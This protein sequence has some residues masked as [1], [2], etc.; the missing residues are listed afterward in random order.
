MHLDVV[1]RIKRFLALDRAAIA[2]SVVMRPTRVAA[3]EE[4]MTG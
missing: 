2:E 3:F 1:A 4:R